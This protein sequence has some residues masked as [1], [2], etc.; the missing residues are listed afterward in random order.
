M[1]KL[2]AAIFSVVAIAACVAGLSACQ[3]DGHDHVWDGGEITTAATDKNNGND[4]WKVGNNEIKSNWISSPNNVAIGYKI[5]EGVSKVHYDLSY[6][7]GGND[8]GRFDVRIWRM[9]A[10]GTLVGNNIFIPKNEEGGAVSV[11]GDIETTAG[12]TIYVIFFH[13]GGWDQVDHFNYVLTN[14]TPDNP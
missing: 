5:S 13:E 12:E 14:V 10:D 2:F 6:T 1:R 11:S 4:G 7:G 9:A 8:P 3:K